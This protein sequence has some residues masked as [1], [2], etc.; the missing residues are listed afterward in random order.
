MGRFLRIGAAVVAVAFMA[1][2][3]RL[4]VGQG[5][6]SAGGEV[7]HQVSAAKKVVADAQQEAQEVKADLQRAE[8]RV[9]K[10][11]AMLKTAMDLIEKAEAIVAPLGKS[12][13]GAGDKTKDAAEKE[14]EASKNVDQAKEKLEKA[15]QLKF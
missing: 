13:A 5:L 6:P 2:G 7:A 8:Q 4:A 10:L 15:K 11:L 12:A 3:L 1:T 14:K 9:D